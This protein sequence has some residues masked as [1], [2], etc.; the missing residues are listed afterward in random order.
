MHWIMREINRCTPNIFFSLILIFWKD[1]Q[2]NPVLCRQNMREMPHKSN[3]MERFGHSLHEYINKTR[4]SC[5]YRAVFVEINSLNANTEIQKIS[6]FDAITNSYISTIIQGNEACRY[7][8]ALHFCTYLIE[9]LRIMRQI[10]RDTSKPLFLS[11]PCV[12]KM[13]LM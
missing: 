9:M 3:S 2:C 1:N 8:P 10:K 12:L 7:G 6:K 11:N 5:F 4:I 13:Q